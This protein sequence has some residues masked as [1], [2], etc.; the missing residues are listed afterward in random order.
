MAQAGSKH[1]K[2]RKA[3]LADAARIAALAGQLSYPS[4]AEEVER[5]L[6][7]LPQDGSHAVFVAE[8]GAGRVVGWAHA[9]VHHFVGSDLRAEV[10]GLVVDETCRDTGVGKVLMARVEEW[11]REKGLAAVTLRSN[12]I[13]DAAHKFYEKLGY[14]RIKT[15]HAF[16]KVL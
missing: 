13:R 2:V 16:R 1:L 6:R 10:A 12:V 15:Q 11:A 3:A 7:D 9:Y 8:D 4:T 5:R 14:T